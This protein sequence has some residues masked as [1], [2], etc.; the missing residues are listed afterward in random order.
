[1][2]KSFSIEKSILE[3][4]LFT[5]VLLAI[6]VV[7]SETLTFIFF[8]WNLF[9]AA[10]PFIIS[11]YIIKRE[12]LNTKTYLLIALWILFLPNAPYIITDLF[13][14]KERENVPKWFDLLIIVSAAWNGLI[15]GIIS[16]LQKENYLKKHI[17]KNIMPYTMPL[18]IAL[19]SFGVYLGRYLRFN[20]WDIVTNIDE[21][22]ITIANHFVHPLRHSV[23]WSFIV[24]FFIMLSLMYATIKKLCHLININT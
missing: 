24:L 22:L 3:A 2:K 7:I 5:M 20:S 12:R 15:M 8:I 1:M 10:I 11:R 13:H 18:I 19:C 23:E 16:M 21:L 4:L 6:R 9:L 17:H 14:L